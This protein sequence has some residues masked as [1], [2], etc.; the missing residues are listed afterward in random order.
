MKEATEVQKNAA[1][2]I[3]KKYEEVSITKILVYG[4]S[5]CFLAGLF[6]RGYKEINKYL[7]KRALYN[8]FLEKVFKENES[9]TAAEVLLIFQYKIKLDKEFF[10]AFLSP[11]DDNQKQFLKTAIKDLPRFN[12]KEGEIE[13]ML[14][15]A[16]EKLETDDCKLYSIEISA[17]QIFLQSD[18][19]ALSHTRYK[20]VY[21]VYKKVFSSNESEGGQ[22]FNNGRALSTI[23]FLSF[24][25]KM[26]EDPELL[27]I[28][29]EAMSID[30]LKTAATKDVITEQRD[31]QVTD[32]TKINKSLDIYKSILNA[33]YKR[34]INDL[35]NKKEALESEAANTG[36][37]DVSTQQQTENLQVAS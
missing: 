23:A 34:L 35:I 14:L 13:N 22:R 24:S 7:K 16:F 33:S 30:D 20:S 11:L 4:S 17:K 18:A 5:L 29:L 2:I 31:V 26:L 1:A 10:S 37:T 3:L 28:D 32:A 9:K 12:V 8:E 15:Q 27:N 25:C 21:G 6:V 19:Q 36:L